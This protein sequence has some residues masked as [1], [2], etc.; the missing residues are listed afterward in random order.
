MQITF[1]QSGGFTGTI[2][3]VRLDAAALPAPER[4]ELEHLVA[5]CGLSGSCEQV[6]KGGRDRRQYDLAIDRGGRVDR[7]SCDD[8]CLPEAARPLV[9]FLAARATPQCR[10]FWSRQPAGMFMSRRELRFAVPTGGGSRGRWSPAGR[11]TA[12]R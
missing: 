3:G 4:A 9:A 1:L 6:S 2:R 7:L 12:A 11:A 5:V 8:G 10:N